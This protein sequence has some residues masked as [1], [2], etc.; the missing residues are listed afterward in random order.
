MRPIS[1]AVDVT[2]YVM[3]DLG[4][5]LHAY[6]LA[7]ARRADRR[8]ARDPGRA[9]PDPRR[10]RPRA[11]P[12]GPA[13]HR[14]PRRRARV[15]AH[16]PR[17]RHGRRGQRGRARRRPTCSSRPRTST[18]SRSPAR[19]VG[20]SCPARR[21]SGS[22]A[23][24][25]RA[26][27]AWRSRATVALLVEHGGG[28]ADPT[29]PTSTDACPCR[30]SSSPLDLPARL[31]GVPYTADE[32]RETLAVDRLRRRRRR[33]PDAVARARAPSWRPD[34][35]VGVDLVEEVARLRGYD[36]IPSI[37]ARSRPAG[38]RPDRRAA[39]PA[40]GR[41]GAG[42][43]RAGRGAQLPVRRDRRSSTRSGLPADDDRRRA[44]RL[45]NPLSDEQ[46]YMR[47]NL[48][49]T[50]LDTARRNVEPRGE[51]RRDLRARPGHAAGRRARPAAP[52]LPGGVR[53]SDE[54]LAAIDAAVPPQ[55]RRVAGVLAGLR[56]PAGWWGPGRRADHTDAIAA[57]R[58]V[59]E[60]V[61]V[62]LVASADA[63]HAPWHPGRC[64]RL[65]TAD[66]TLVGHAGELHPNVVAALGLPARAVGVRAG[67]RRAAGG[68]VARARSRRC[69]SRRSP[70]PRRTSRSWSARRCRRPTCSTRS[71]SARPRARPATSSRRSGCST[72]TPAPQ[73]G[74]D[75]KSL[76]FALRLR[77]ADRTLTAQESAAVRETRRRRGAPPVRGDAA[78]LSIA[79]AG[80]RR[81][82]RS[83]GAASSPATSHRMCSLNSYRRVVATNRTNSDSGPGRHER[84]LRR[85]PTKA[86]S[87][88]V[89]R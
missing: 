8:A 19:P 49:V 66:G 80:P 87:T 29:S 74:D 46:P 11:R 89:L 4:Q 81:P 20:T 58:L 42:R 84:P 47:T 43:V 12:R 55:P 45:V 37:A 36:A 54:E 5:P 28:V 23:A 76:A 6:D 64:A 38:A 34:L 82:D 25:T 21:P 31:V 79:S 70:S 44:V 78:R 16:R 48:L 73:V 83:T 14:Q 60:V 35:V 2:N 24:P 69:R 32:V 10:R 68:G 27:A 63:D 1:L 85:S 3:L 72:C 61:G 65:T 86:S 33:S 51:R 39:G 22:S 67:P 75:R 41:A 71:G 59:A 77:A 56:E 40:L 15:A 53:P 9:D 26:A 7:H 50:L 52:R 57:A 62:E 13:H 17:G 88:C 30:R 18:R